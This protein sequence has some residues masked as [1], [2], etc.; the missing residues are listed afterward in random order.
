MYI[1]CCQY[2]MHIEKSTSTS[3]KIL[4]LQYTK[5]LSTFLIKAAYHSKESKPY[6]SSPFQNFS[7]LTDFLGYHTGTVGECEFNQVKILACIWEAPR[8]FLGWDTA[9]TDFPILFL[10][11]V[12]L[13]KLGDRTLK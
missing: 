11:S 3:I 10:C 9:Y 13:G 6:T 8:S 5:L 12:L 7:H 1:C 2:C 4:I